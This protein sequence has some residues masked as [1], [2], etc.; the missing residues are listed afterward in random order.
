MLR[1]GKVNDIRQLIS[2]YFSNKIIVSINDII[3]MYKIA[4]IDEIKEIQSNVFSI[5]LYA[6]DKE[7]RMTDVRVTLSFNPEVK[8]DDIIICAFFDD[9]FSLRHEEVP[10][11][12]DII[13]INEFASCVECRAFTNNDGSGYILLN[14]GAFVDQ[15][16]LGVQELASLKYHPNV[17]SIIWFNK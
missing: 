8:G 7:Y 1:Y 14:N 10:E 15:H 9:V 12:G 16:S 4:G 3:F 6:Y 11:Y 2:A 17:S 13:E 5:L